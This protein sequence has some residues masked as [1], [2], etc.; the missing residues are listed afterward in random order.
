[1]ANRVQ[2]FK[3]F[4]VWR[5]QN[6]NKMRFAVTRSNT[7]HRWCAVCLVLLLT[8]L[9]FTVGCGGS[10]DAIVSGK[11][12]WKGE[13][14][15]YGFIAFAPVDG[16]TKTAGAPIEAGKYRAADV[17]PGEKFVQITAA[18]P[19][20]TAQGSSDPMTPPAIDIP[21]NA[22]GNGQQHKIGPGAQTLDLALSP[23]E[24]H[25]GSK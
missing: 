11:V 14:L 17:P 1:V 6:K 23:P 20:R 2:I 16:K 24:Q 12:T 5:G 8:C 18:D 10:S 21:H 13:P 25:Q 7:M 4:T 15:P 9:T 22:K 3:L 19:P